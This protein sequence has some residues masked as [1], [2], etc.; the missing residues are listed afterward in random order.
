MVMDSLTMWCT[1]N[2]L[3]PVSHTL[4]LMEVVP[5]PKMLNIVSS[6]MP[7]QNITQW[8]ERFCGFYCEFKTFTSYHWGYYKIP[9]PNYKLQIKNYKLQITNYKLQITNYKLKIKN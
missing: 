4:P 3:L 7:V 5:P 2:F 8:T 9:E 6:K 1:L